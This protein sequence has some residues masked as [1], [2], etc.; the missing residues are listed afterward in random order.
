M[1]PL[2]TIIVPVFRTQAY[3]ARCL[4][5]LIAQTLQE[6]EI[7]VIDDCSDDDSM[8]IVGEFASRDERIRI[9]SN[10]QNLGL[11][12]TR[13]IGDMNAKGEW[14][15]YVDSDDYIMPNLCQTA[16]T[17]IHSL[18]VDI[19]AFR[20]KT[21]GFYRNTPK[22]SGACEPY[23]L[24][25]PSKSTFTP[26]VWNKIYKKEL[27]VQADSILACVKSKITL[28]EDIL[29]SFVILALC[30]SAYM[31]PNE[32]YVYCANK[33]SSSALWQTFDTIE[34]KIASYT[35]IKAALRLCV[36]RLEN[37]AESSTLDSS[38]S[39]TRSMC[40][41][42]SNKLYTILDYLIVFE[43][44]LLPPK[45]FCDFPY[46]KYILASLKVWFRPQSIIRL[47]MWLIS[48]GKI[49]R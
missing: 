45:S 21:Q 18:G 27:I 49:K 4:E 14:V 23:S 48:L 43:C 5:S 8:Q 3:I 47:G 17:Y 26:Y 22:R 41:Q 16:Y 10:P 46:P 6:I 11:F 15:I 38:V 7:L 35:H 31:L 42:A 28:G 44:R 39:K 19:V 34:S 30:D 32:L 24:L 36:E 9:I 37:L 33:T 20:A 29:K 2:I 1:K 25:F 12:H 40:I 13:I